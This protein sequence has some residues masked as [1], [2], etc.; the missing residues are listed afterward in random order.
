MNPMKEETNNPTLDE[1][2]Q[3]FLEFQDYL[4]SKEKKLKLPVT[5]TMDDIDSL[6]LS[7]AE[8]KVDFMKNK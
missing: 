6:L 5:F 8:V 3:E 7:L 4:T 1:L 2:N